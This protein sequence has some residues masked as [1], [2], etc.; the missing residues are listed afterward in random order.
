MP[1]MGGAPS[2][3]VGR[4]TLR[5]RGALYMIAASCL[6]ALLLLGSAAAMPRTLLLAAALLRAW[7]GLWL[8]PVLLGAML[9]VIALHE[10]AHVAVL[11]AARL[12][13][14]VR[15]HL[16]RLA[17]ITEVPVA[18]P[19]RVALA[20]ALAPQPAVLGALALAARAVPGAWPLL[21]VLG[22]VAVAGS[23]S[24]LLAAAALALSRDGE[25][26]VR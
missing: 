19:R 11:A 10:A 26:R 14:R 6:T 22:V 2:V 8:P 21:T 15:L 4:W 13:V 12:P 5:Q 3:R 17:V 1:A 18:L 24:D 7:Y 23:S 16:R 25:V 20:S 9:P